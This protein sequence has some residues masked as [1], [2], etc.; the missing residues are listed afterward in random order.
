MTNQQ[1]NKLPTNEND[2]PKQTDSTSNSA[3]PLLTQEL[4]TELNDT[5]E[6]N[7]HI[8]SLAETSERD[9]NTATSQSLSSITDSQDSTPMPRMRQTISANSLNYSYGK[10]TPT[11]CSNTEHKCEDIT[12]YVKKCPKREKNRYVTY[13]GD[14]RGQENHTLPATGSVTNYTSNR[15]ETSGSG[16]TGRKRYFS[17]ITTPRKSTTTYS[18]GYPKT[19]STSQ[20][21][22][23]RRRSK[24]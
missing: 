13:S 23:P 5:S 9:S 19:P 6:T 4:W 15:Q 18:D 10:N 17:M 11:G 16:T 2:A 22:A 7:Q 14:Q 8:W 3:F 12:K 20:S 24:L 21:K 1:S